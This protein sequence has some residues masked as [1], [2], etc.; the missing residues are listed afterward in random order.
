MKR[1]YLALLLLLTLLLSG[2]TAM[3]SPLTDGAATLVPGTDPVLPEAQAPD[4]LSTRET[5]TLYF[6]YL[7]EPYLA[8]ETRTIALSPSRPYELSLLT[9]LLSGPGTRSADLTALFPAGTRVLSTATKGRTLFVTL[10]QEIMNA[11]PDEPSSWRS[12]AFYQTEVPLRRRLCMQSLVAT[13]T[14]NCDVDRVQVL[15]EQTGQTADS[16]RLRARYFM[17]DPDPNALVGPMTRD[18]SLLLSPHTTMDVI[19]SLLVAQDWQRLYAYVAG[20]DPSTGMERVSYQDFMTAMGNLP[21]VTDYRFSGGSITKEGMQAT[22]TLSA[23]LL[24][25][26]GQALEAEGCI[27]RLRR[28]NGLWRITLSQLTGWLEDLT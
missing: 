12:D 21:A 4:S 15:V 8:P 9:E 13:V 6:R 27:L 23:S 1:W 17:L 28:D 18:E 24:T 5:A 7:D 11:Y 16:L 26:S 25:R 19:L 3:V 22:F 10:S 14:E 20:R 2:C